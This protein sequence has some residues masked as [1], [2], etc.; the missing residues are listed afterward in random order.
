[1]DIKLSDMLAKRGIDAGNV[2]YIGDDLNDYAAM[3]FCGSS[4]CPADAVS[5]IRDLAD[6]V[7]PF[8]GGCG[9]VRDIIERAMRQT[10]RWDEV[11]ALYGIKT[12]AEI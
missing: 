9:A 6:Y 4:A 3:A 11:L 12:G 10:G 8:A 1:M 5:E 7:S 2:M